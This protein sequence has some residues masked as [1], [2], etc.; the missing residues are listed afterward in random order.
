MNWVDGSS[1]AGSFK[2]GQYEI[3]NYTFIDGKVQKIDAAGV[4]G[5]KPERNAAP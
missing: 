2:H 5:S 4:L 1:Y 3:G